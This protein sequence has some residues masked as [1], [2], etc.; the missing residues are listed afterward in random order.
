MQRTILSV[1]TER[2]TV[3]GDKEMIVELQKRAN[4]VINAWT[5]NI[6]KELF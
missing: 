6:S 1:A 2:S 4:T 3:S 5:T